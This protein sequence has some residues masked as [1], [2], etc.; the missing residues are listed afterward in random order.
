MK[1]NLGRAIS[2]SMIFDFNNFKCNKNIYTL[3]RKYFQTCRIFPRYTPKSYSTSVDSSTRG[4]EFQKIVEPFKVLPVLAPVFPAKAADI[5]ILTEPNKFFEEI[6]KKIE[7]AKK[8]ITIAS[9]YIGHEEHEIIKSLEKALERNNNL[10]VDILLDCLR[11]TRETRGASSA[12]LLLP[13]VK[14]YPNRFHLSMYHTPEL[15]GWMKKLG[16]PRFNETIGLMHIK[17]YLLMMT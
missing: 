6:K 2:K 4:S 11:G 3:G 8:R 5:N 16:P 17:A 14:M 1:K 13:L 10:E 12:S 7:S 9:L 15:T